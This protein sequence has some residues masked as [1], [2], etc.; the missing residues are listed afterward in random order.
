[1]DSMFKMDTMIKA[2]ELFERL[3]DLQMRNLF[4]WI[5]AKP[6]SLSV[7][8]IEIEAKTRLGVKMLKQLNGGKT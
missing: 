7:C 6:Y 8:Q 2:K 3:D 4:I 1:M 5:E